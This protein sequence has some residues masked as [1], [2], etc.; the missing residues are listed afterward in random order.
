MGPTVPL[1][2]GGIPCWYNCVLYTDAVAEILKR[3][4]PLASVVGVESESELESSLVDSGPV[5]PPLTLSTTIS[6]VQV[7]TQ[8]GCLLGGAGED[9]VVLP[10]PPC[11]VVSVL[12]SLYHCHLECLYS[13][14][15]V[16]QMKGLCLKIL[17]PV[18]WS[19]L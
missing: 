3:E 14:F 11:T 17:S 19:S 6:G 2:S 5:Q 15:F 4:L 13:V 1:H 18:T 8:T 12:L 10:L 9:Y 7:D 16:S